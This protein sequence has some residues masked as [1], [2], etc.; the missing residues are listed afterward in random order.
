M[1]GIQTNRSNISLPM[2]V[3]SEI[4]QK[5]QEAS[6]VM[7]LA[8]QISLPG[9]GLTIPVI[10]SDPEASW[11][12]ET[13]KKPVSNPGLSTKNMQAYTLA[14]IVPFSNQFRRDMAA[15]Y[16]ACIQ[17]LPNALGSKFD[18]T[19]FGGTAVPGSNFDNLASCT[20]VSI[21]PETYSDVS[22][23][24]YN[25]LVQADLNIAVNGGILNGYALSPQAKGI[26]LAARDETGRPLFINNVA[27]GAVPMILGAPTKISKGAYISGSPNV[28]GFAGD[29][30]K[31]MYGVV[32]G[33]NIS[34]SDQ[35]TL[36]LG[37]GQT[38]NLFQ[39]NM[40]AVRAEIEIGFVADTTVFNKLT[41]AGSTP[42]F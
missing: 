27:E 41:S 28:V 13:E 8:R 40:F 9:R 1:S 12:G 10:T 25:A 3:S 39:Q 15:L 11:V 38:I 16:D 26:L 18:N 5:T 20:A 7:Q 32:E 35:A 4:I 17:R 34:I 6:A 19:V 36:D 30:T 14:V 24:A 23:A 21:N 37:N 22:P 29:W 31:A 2:D 42:S 33:V